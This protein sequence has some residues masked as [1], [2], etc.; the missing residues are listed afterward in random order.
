[1][2]DKENRDVADRVPAKDRVTNIDIAGFVISI[3]S[4]IVDVG[5]DCNLAFRYYKSNEYDA[6]LATLGFILVPAL[7]NTAFSLR[8]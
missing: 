3:I 1:M 8:M 2:C 5:F 4:H 6:F 7:I